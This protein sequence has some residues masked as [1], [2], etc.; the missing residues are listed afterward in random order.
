MLLQHSREYI[1]FGIKEHFAKQCWEKRDDALVRKEE[2]VFPKE[3]ATGIERLEFPFELFHAND[4][5]DELDVLG[6]Q[7]VLVLALRIL[8]EETY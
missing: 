1:L 8:D 4:S 2:P 7:E 5:R 3:L 6:S